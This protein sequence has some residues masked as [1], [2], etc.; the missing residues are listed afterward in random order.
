MRAKT[1][2]GALES[3]AGGSLAI[4]STEPGGRIAYAS[5]VAES[6]FGRLEGLD[7]SDPPPCDDPRGPFAGL[8]SLWEEAR[9]R[10][11][12]TEPALLRV[13]SNGVSSFL[14]AQVLP[15]PSRSPSDRT[16]LFLDVTRHLTGSEA[17]S[18]LISQLAHDLRSPLTSIA[19]ATELLLSGRIGS[20]Q[21]AQQKLLKIVDEGA[22]KMAGIIDRAAIEG[23]EGGTQA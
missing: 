4:I 3:L 7:L 15:N 17:V 13:K 1:V 5:P 8:L 20:L 19:G 10:S 23:S 9:S 11:L 22:G 12:P 6:I 21:S 2:P 18:R 16:F 14:W